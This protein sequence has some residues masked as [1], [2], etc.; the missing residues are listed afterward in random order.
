MQGNLINVVKI[1]AIANNNSI[2]INKGEIL[3][4]FWELQGKKY[5]MHQKV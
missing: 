2:H 5:H 1:I 4:L 3:N